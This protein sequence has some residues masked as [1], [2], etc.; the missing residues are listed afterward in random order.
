MVDLD[1][2]IAKYSEHTPSISAIT[3]FE[4]MRL[5]NISL[6]FISNTK[7]EYR[8]K[9][10]AE[11][12]NVPYVFNAQKP[13]PNS[14]LHVMKTNGYQPGETAYIGDQIFT[15]TLAAK[16]AKVTTIIVRPL[17]LKNPLLFLRYL[18]EIPIRAICANKM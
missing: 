13:S 14:L 10:F 6:Y 4:N 18:A 17:S 16:R 1:N 7:R 5:N 12:L 3:W 9:A 15:D 11:A 2:T 8:V